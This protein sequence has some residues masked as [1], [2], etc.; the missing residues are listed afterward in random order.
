[1]I[2]EEQKQKVGLPVDVT[3]FYYG[4][5]NEKNVFVIEVSPHLQ[6]NYKFLKQRVESGPFAPIQ[7]KWLDSI[8]ARLLPELKMTSRTQTLLQ[9]LCAEVSDDFRNAIV[10]HTGI[11]ISCSLSVNE[12]HV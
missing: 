6:M 5:E 7:Q 11:S 4:P 8:T 3:F 10:K 1:M 12:H 9:E 2:S